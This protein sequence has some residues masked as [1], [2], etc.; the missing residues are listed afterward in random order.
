M[1]QY[2]ILGGISIYQLRAMRMTAAQPRPVIEV[3]IWLLIVRVCFGHIPVT[4]PQNPY[5][6]I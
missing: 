1:M 2:F 5:Q 6:S 3:G 4:C